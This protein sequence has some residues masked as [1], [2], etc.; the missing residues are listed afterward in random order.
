MKLLSVVGARPQFVKVAPLHQAISRKNNL[1]HLILHTGQHY[2]FNLSEVFF[3]ELAIP[4]PFFHLEVNERSLAS[5]IEPMQK[6]IEIVLATESPDIVIV[7]GDTN[8]TLAGALAAKNFD[9]KLAHIEAGLRS[10]NNAMPEEKNRVATDKLSDLLFCPTAESV[11][12]LVK[13]GLN[14]NNK[15]ILSG[16][17][18]L[19]AYNYYSKK[20]GEHT[21]LII[22]EEPFILCTLHRQSLVQSSTKLF[23]V[24]KALNEINRQIPIIVPAHPR[25]RHVIT[26]FGLQPQFTI[27]EPVGYLNM[28]ALLKACDLVMTDSGGLQ[29][30]A[31]FAKKICITLRDETEWTELVQAHVNFIAGDSSAEKI[32]AT[33]NN[34]IRTK[35]T[36]DDKFYGEGNAAEIIVQ[37]LTS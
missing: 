17:I 3:K 5:S 31:F 9:I 36:F 10:Y 2:D 32:I 23:E 26:E 1:Q 24:I 7:L 4:Q 18:M 28:L 35:G 29:K 25:L 37:G 21:N 14:T 6:K 16:D 27:I 8:S 20:I 34:A 12:N 22:P 19:D 15:V 33:F 13:E 11:N 30:E